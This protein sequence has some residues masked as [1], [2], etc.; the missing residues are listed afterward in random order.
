MCGISGYIGIKDISKFKIK[1]TLN[2]MKNRGPDNQ[3]YCEINSDKNKIFFLHSRLSIIDLKKRSNQPFYS[4]GIYIIFNGEIY[5]YVELRNLLIKKKVKFKTN[6]DTEVLLKYYQYYGTDCLKYFEGM[7]SFAIYDVKKKITFLSRDRFGEKP[8]YYFN[9]KNDGIYF[10]SEIK[11]IK[12]LIQKKFAVNKE[13]IISFLNFGYKSLYKK[14]DLFFNEIKELGGGEYLIINH[15]NNLK[16]FKYWKPKITENKYISLNETISEVR[17]K[18]TN[19][20]KLRTRSDV[21]I[22]FT[23]SGGVDSAS[24]VS[25][26]SKK[27]NLK[28]R[29]Y[30][31]IDDDKRYDESENIDEI[32]KDLECKNK[33]IIIKNEKN[34]E[35]LV[36]IINYNEK[37]LASIAQYNHAILMKQINKDGYRVCINGTMADE[38]FAGYY[39]H[40]LL[41]FSSIKKEK[42]F[43]KELSQWKKNV[44]PLI[45]NPIFQKYDLYL[46][47]KNFRGHVYDNHSELKKYLKIK[48]KYSFNE[49]FFTKDLLKNRMLNEIFF[50]NTP[51]FLD[52]EDLNSMRYSIENRSP[53]LDRDLFKT[54]TSTTTKNYIHNGYKKYILR[55]SMSGIVNKKILWDI[56]KKGFNADISTL[57]KLKSNKFKDFILDRNSKIFK[58][59]DY[60]KFQYLL[61]LDYFPNYLSK[62]LFNVINCKIFLDNF[63]IE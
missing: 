47:D 4:D 50:E 45:R 30:S 29:T 52:N 43:N 16:T 37:P 8:L 17:K 56:N 49:K 41:Y 21:P 1:N 9:S 14:G 58:Y 6:S 19:S 46:K 31:I 27:L 53:F 59:V 55:K 34:L 20:L 32:V 35:N 28:I 2:L 13:K 5:N 60:N 38:L 18:L 39:D 44:L 10:G 33:K 15:N 62:F 12:S 51:P 11:F 57:F 26:A 54:I 24:L 42:K 61:D 48:K 36:D 22:A 23:L 40:H 63:D 25:I 7:W 3:S